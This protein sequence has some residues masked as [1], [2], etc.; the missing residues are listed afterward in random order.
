M[1]RFG[2]I[3]WATLVLMILRH[4]LYFAKFVVVVVAQLQTQCTCEVL[5]EC[6]GV[7]T[8]YIRMVKPL[9]IMLSKLLSGVLKGREVTHST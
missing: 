9:P 1:F 6:M 3:A 2:P 7:L 4:I 8:Y 5:M